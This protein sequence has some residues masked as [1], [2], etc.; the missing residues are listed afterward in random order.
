MKRLMGNGTH[1][2]IGDDGVNGKTS[3]FVTSFGAPAGASLAAAAELLNAAHRDLAALMADNIA[4]GALFSRLV[5]I[6][7]AV[8]SAEAVCW[9]ASQALDE[10]GGAA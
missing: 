10:A 5:M 3:L 7:H 4:T 8:G 1:L 6:S 2:D 9:D